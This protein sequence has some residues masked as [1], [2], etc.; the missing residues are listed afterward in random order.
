MKTL[1]PI[2]SIQ[3]TGFLSG[4]LNS[5]RTDASEVYSNEIYKLTFKFKSEF[6]LPFF[7]NPNSGALIEILFPSS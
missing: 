2:I 3:S 7:Q 5:F 4:S 1:S 6:A